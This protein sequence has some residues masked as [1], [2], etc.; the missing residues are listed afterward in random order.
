[1][2]QCLNTLCLTARIGAIQ[3]FPIPQT[4]YLRFTA[5]NETMSRDF[6]R[7]RTSQV[8]RN[9]GNNHIRFIDFNGIPNAQRQFFQNTDVVYA[10]TAHRRAFQFHRVKDCN[11]IHK[12]CTGSVPFNFPQ[13][14]FCH[15]VCPFESNG[16]FREFGCPSQTLAVRN[17]VECQHQPV[18]C[19]VIAFNMFPEIFH[20]IQ[21]GIAC[22]HF[23][24]HH[25]KAQRSQPL[26]IFC[27]AV[28]KFFSFGTYQRKG[29]KLH[30]SLC[31]NFTVQLS[32]SAAAKVSGVFVSI[33]FTQFLIDSLE[34]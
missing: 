4:A 14:G 32:Y 28:G 20:R 33:P 12:P 17:A 23:G 5:A 34:F 29:K 26:H 6:R 10:G 25:R 22:N 24:F 11:G 30:I 7:S 3:C 31:G 9:L 21:Y 19:N 18:R 8:F 16:V 2:T 15:F 27:F 13:S 1:M